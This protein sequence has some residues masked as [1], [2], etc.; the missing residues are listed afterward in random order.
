M[1]MVIWP[2]LV[3]YPTAHWV[4]GGGWLGQQNEVRSVG[5]WHGVLARTFKRVIKVL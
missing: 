1:F 3:Y 5:I 4:W 2:H